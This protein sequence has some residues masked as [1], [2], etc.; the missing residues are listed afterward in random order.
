MNEIVFIDANVLCGL[1]NNKDSLHEKSKKAIG[2]LRESSFA[3]SNFI[4]LECYTIIS[5]RTSKKNSILFREYMFT[6]K[7]YEVFWIDRKLEDE[8]WTIFQSIKDKNFSYVDA[9][10]LAAMKKGGI[11]DLLS[12]DTGFAQLQKIFGFTLIGA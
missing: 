3:I 7:Q 1:F 11:T 5:Q 12:F 10:I 9:S 8:T 2:L 6:N 4:L